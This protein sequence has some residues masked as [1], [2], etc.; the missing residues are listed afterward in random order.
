M[1]FWCSYSGLIQQTP[2][3]N[4]L[5]PRASTSPPPAHHHGY[6]PFGKP[7]KW[8]YGF[9]VDVHTTPLPLCLQQ[10][11]TE[12]SR[13]SPNLSKVVARALAR[14]PFAH[15]SCCLKEFDSG[16]QRAHKR[17]R[18]QWQYGLNEVEAGGALQRTV[19]WA[20][21]EGESEDEAEEGAEQESADVI[22]ID[23]DSEEVSAVVE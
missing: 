21:G 3:Y 9:D 10:M 11:R 8:N 4:P 18:R 1:T 12:Q 22:I 13:P 6:H 2:H 19:V 5:L 20:A 17:K 23:S 7:L 14:Q 16:G 15:L